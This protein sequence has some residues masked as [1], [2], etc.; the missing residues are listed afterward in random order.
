M[1]EEKLYTNK[2]LIKITIITALIT[3][4][5]N[6]HLIPFAIFWF[7]FFATF[8]LQRRGVKQILFSVTLL[9]I[10]I[11]FYLYG[12][13]ALMRPI[14]N[15][16][17]LIN[18]L[19]WDL[20]ID[21]TFSATQFKLPAYFIICAAWAMIPA[22][23]IYCI[24]RKKHNWDLLQ[25]ITKG[26]NTKEEASP[27]QSKSSK[28]F[29]LGR[30]KQNR[31]ITLSEKNANRHT[32]VVGTTGSGKTNTL[33]L[34]TETAIDKGWPIIFVDGKGDE[35]L[36][37]NLTSFAKDK[38]REVAYFSMNKKSNTYYNPLVAGDYTSKKDRI[39]SLFDDQNEYYKS[40]SEGYIQVVFKILEK[41]KISIDMHQASEYIQQ[42]ALLKLLRNSVENETIT[43]AQATKLSNEL[44]RHETAKKDV[45]SIA[46][47]INNIC[48]SSSG[49]FFD[50]EGE[51]KQVIKLNEMLDKN[52]VVY[53][54]LPTLKADAFVN[55][56]GKLII[57]DIK[58]TMHDRLEDEKTNPVLIIFDEFSSFAGKQVTPLLAQGRST[59]V[60][61]VIGSQGFADFMTGTDGEKALDQTL[62]NINNFIVHQLGGYKDREICAKL[63]GSK[64]SQKITT[65]INNEADLN[66][67]SIRYGYEWNINPS[68]FDKLKA[69]GDAFFISINKKGNKE[70]I[71]FQTALSK[72][73]LY[74]KEKKDE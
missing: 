34:L 53:F 41:C 61:C 30:D 56:L 69:K 18:P 2:E 60:H 28:D 37:K 27:K 20:W 16:Y 26:S 64:K 9:A 31:E 39:I 24:V 11:D 13:K 46:T 29:L 22:G 48:G 40:V 62:Q 36:G 73:T 25:E 19:P 43:K 3:G 59:G 32:L 35:Q 66:K 15:F 42:E 12:T 44:N 74:N 52:A 38:G 47:H 17:P 50:T 68:D 63:S 21:I 67:G 8:D 49:E 7:I 14:M 54:K 72:I 4:L 1:L 57:N 10:L 33:C 70:S 45:S 6:I 65:Q 23:Y 51:G 55:I 58:A 71:R 5:L